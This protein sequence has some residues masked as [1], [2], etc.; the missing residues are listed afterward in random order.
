MRVWRSRTQRGFSCSALMPWQ[1]S[2]SFGGGDVMTSVRRQFGKRLG[3]AF[4]MLAALQ[5]S[6]SAATQPGIPAQV[7]RPVIIPPQRDMPA[8]QYIRDRINELGRGF[9][10]RV[11]IAVR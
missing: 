10:G 5:V 7:Q 2:G 11:G 3:L 1:M 9:D 8:P 6:A 4:V